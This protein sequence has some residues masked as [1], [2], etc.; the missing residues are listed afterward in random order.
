MLIKLAIAFSLLALTVLIHAV[1]LAFVLRWLR[2]STTAEDPRFGVRTWLLIR[3]ASWA[4]AIHCTEIAVWALFY[5][6]QECLPDLE[7]SLY[8]SLVTYTTLGYGDLVLTQ[9]WRLLSG[10]EAL[11]GI[12]MCGWTTGGFF[13]IVSRMYGLRPDSRD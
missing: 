7:S 5:W 4:V 9:G 2:S 8:F 12:L 10:V 1:G 13:A 3:I 11:T 6:W